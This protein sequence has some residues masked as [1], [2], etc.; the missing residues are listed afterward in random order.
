MHSNIASPK[1]ASYKAIK[2][3]GFM[4][5]VL[6]ITATCFSCIVKLKRYCRCCASRIWEG[7]YNF[8]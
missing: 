8:I 4:F 7:V 1:K 2:S 5:S 3:G 6:Y